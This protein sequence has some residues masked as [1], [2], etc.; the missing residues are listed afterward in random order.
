[1]NDRYNLR[2][3]LRDGVTL[4]ADVYLPGAPGPHPA[5]VTRTPYNKNTPEAYAKGR[6]MTDR[7]YAFVWMDVRGRGDSDGVFVPWRA[8][9]KDGYDAVEWVAAQDWCTGDVATWGWSYSA[10]SQWLTALEQPPH[11]RAMITYG[12]PQDPYPIG[13]WPTGTHP[14]VMLTWCRFV[15]GRVTQHIDAIDWTA[16]YEHLPIVEQDEIAGFSSDYWHADHAHPTLDGYWEP[17]R[18][19]HR[20]SE[21]DLPVLHVTG[22]YDDGAGTYRN[23]ERMSSS[24]ATEQARSAQ[25]LIVGPWVHE[26]NKDRRIGEIDFGPDAIIDL[27]AIETAWLDRWVRRIEN[28]DAGVRVRIFVMGPNEWRDEREWPLARTA[29]TAYYLDGGNA[30]SRFG[31][32]KLTPIASTEERTDTYLYDPLRPVPYIYDPVWFQIGGPDDYSAIEQRGDVLVYTSDPLTEPLEVTGPVRAI[33]HAA[34]SAL[35]TD[36]TAKLL[37]VHPNGFSQRLCDGAVRGRFRNGIETD[38][39]M[40]PG[41]VY[42]LEI[43]LWYTS[44]VFQSGHRIRIEIASSAFPK[45]A[46]NT[47]TGNVLAT[48]TETVIAENTIYHGGR[49]DSHLVLPA[50][51][52]RKD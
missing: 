26:A 11:L 27:D 48:D 17:M 23:F 42:R 37:D 15:D 36:F 32:G 38:E 45:Y 24:A 29:Y 22:W 43:D 46:R 4:S 34:T 39:L 20:I 13:E 40:E 44:H 9:A 28:A 47:N 30:N 10:Y 31:D 12:S 49:F 8:E 2:V 50:V 3:P 1:V 7:G 33:I 18:Y 14:P 41:D 25:T 52:S 6:A 16:V 35:D 21:I 19:S 51:P 5:I